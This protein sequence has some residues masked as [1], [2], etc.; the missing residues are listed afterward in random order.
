[1]LFQLEM[2]TWYDINIKLDAP[3]RKLLK[4][5]FNHLGILAKWLSIRLQAK[6]LWIPTSS[7]I[8]IQNTAHHLDS[9]VK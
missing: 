8:S 3:Y 6:Q 5:Q 1:M 9:L 2:R 4:T 7:Q